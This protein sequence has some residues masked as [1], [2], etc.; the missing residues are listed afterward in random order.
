MIDGPAAGGYPIVNYEYAVVST[1]QPDAARASAIRAFLRWV[2]T[3][4][5][6]ASYVDAVGFQ[7]LPAALV[8]LGEQQIEEIGP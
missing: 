3:T 6:Q 4:G 7:P 2:I 8:A 5:N 1:R